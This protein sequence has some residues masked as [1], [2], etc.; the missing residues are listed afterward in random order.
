[1]QQDKLLPKNHPVSFELI[2]PQGQLV[3][4]MV[5]TNGV[6]GFYNFSTKTEVDATYDTSVQVDTKIAAIPDT[7]LSGYDTAVF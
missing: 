7:D 1:M 3:T 4:K 6:N 5:K 2:N